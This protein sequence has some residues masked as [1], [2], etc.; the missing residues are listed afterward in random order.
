MTDKDIQPDV[1]DLELLSAG[2]LA[3]LQDVIYR[4]MNL[5]RRGVVNADELPAL[6][7]ASNQLGV[8]WMRRIN[9]INRER[10][11]KKD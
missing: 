10:L 5:V 7:T 2:T 4:R 3:R 6:T 8:A 9:R 11:L 1:M